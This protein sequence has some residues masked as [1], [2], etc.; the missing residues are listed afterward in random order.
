MDIHNFWRVRLGLMVAACMVFL[1]VPIYEVIES[2]II[3][4]WTW[5]GICIAGCQNITFE[6]EPAWLLPIYLGVFPLA[7]LAV[8]IASGVLARRDLR[9]GGGVSREAR[10]LAQL[11]VTVFLF[12]AVQDVVEVAGNLV[13]FPSYH[14]MTLDLAGICALPLAAILAGRIPASD[15]IGK[16]KSKCR[17]TAK[18]STSCV[19]NG[20]GLHKAGRKARVTAVTW[21]PVARR[22]AKRKLRNAQAS[23]N[24]EKN[25]AHATRNTKQP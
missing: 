9:A 6:Y 19:S 25:R 11:G 4:D 12:V 22:E 16:N 5:G 20:I 14:L 23:S 21:M 3:L 15:R 7:P 18:G 8:G 10:I 13:M 1:A 2:S 24:A 17:G